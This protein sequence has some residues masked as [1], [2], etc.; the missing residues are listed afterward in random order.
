M[1]FFLYGVFVKKVNSLCLQYCIKE[2]P[3]RIFFIF[4]IFDFPKSK[5]LLQVDSKFL[6][7]IPLYFFYLLYIAFITFEFYVILLL[8]GNFLDGMK[9]SVT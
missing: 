7:Y 9:L 3:E 2:V 5:I 6:I 1:S 8:K 4:W